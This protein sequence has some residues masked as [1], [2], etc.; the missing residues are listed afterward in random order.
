M[1]EVGGLPPA[2][3]PLAHGIPL[4]VAPIR[5]DQPVVAAQVTRAGAGIRLKFAHVTKT[6][7]RTAV[8]RALSEPELRAAAGRVQASFAAAGGVPA[9]AR[10]LEE[11]T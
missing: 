5:D 7:L 4:V 9:A 6:S 10:L 11:M 1:H 3:H 8:L 2:G